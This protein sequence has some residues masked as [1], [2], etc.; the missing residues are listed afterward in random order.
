[1]DMYQ[2]L[3]QG[4]EIYEL[5]LGFDHPETADAYTK[6]ALAYQEQGNFAASSPWIRRAFTIFYKCFGPHDDITLN[7]YEYLKSIEI[8]IDSR[9]EQVSYEDLPQVIYEMEK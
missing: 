3:M 1:M 8:N 7:V 4:I 6:M 5:M 9:L 2:N